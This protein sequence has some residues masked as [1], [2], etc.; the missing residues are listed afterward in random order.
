MRTEH[1]SNRARGAHPQPAGGLAKWRGWPRAILD[2]LLPRECALCESVLEASESASGM[3]ATCAGALPGSGA[4][5][6]AGCGLRC[7]ARPCPACQAGTS[8][9]AP[10]TLV[11]CDYAPPADRLVTAFKYGRRIALGRAI[12]AAMAERL[13]QHRRQHALPPGVVLVAVPIA[14]SRLARRGFD[15]AAV[16]ARQVG[17]RCGLRVVAAGLSRVR[18]TRPQPGLARDERS[19]NLDGAMAGSAA[20]AGRPVV[21]VDD[22]ITSG[23]TLYEAERAVRAAGG[24]PSLRLAFARTPAPGTDGEWADAAT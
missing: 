23:A 24:E 20:L 19:R 14:P 15:Q 16:L 3:C 4:T 11:C 13:E 10:P 9:P 18:D 21:L 1:P 5:R 22:V 12:G 8:T 7:A 6:C 17:G 2:L